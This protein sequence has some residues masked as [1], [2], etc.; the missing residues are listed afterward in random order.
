MSDYF[1]AMGTA[2]YSKLAAGTA[3]IGALGGTAIYGDQAPDGSALPYIVFSHSAG[4]PDNITPRDMRSGVWFVRAYSATKAQ[5]AQIDGLVDDLLH[6]GSLSVSGWTTF[7][8]ARE[9]DI[10]LIENP[11]NGKRI[12]MTG[13]MY[14]IRLSK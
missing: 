2:L 6:E 8:I 1:G 7:W 5:A 11:P 14:R 4:A 10:S 13:G 9:E 3:L 12:H